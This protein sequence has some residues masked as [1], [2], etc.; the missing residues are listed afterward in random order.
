M[1]QPP[2]IL[3][4]ID[5]LDGYGLSRQ[6]ELLVAHQLA[7]GMTPTV[8]A[9]RGRRGLVRR[10]GQQGLAIR[11]LDRRWVRDP[12]VAV[13]LVSELRRHKYDLLHLWGHSAVSY[14]QAVDRFVPRGPRITSVP[15]EELLV[16]ID[17]PP[18]VSTS[19]AEFLAKEQLPA[20][21]KLIAVAGPLV[22]S[23]QVD[24]AIWHF[25]LVRTLDEEVCLLIFGDGPDNHRLERFTRLTSEPSAVRFLGYRRDFRELL[26]HVDVFWHT[27]K[28]ERALPQTVLEAMAA[29]IPVVVNETGNCRKLVDHGNTGYLVPENDRAIFA[30]YTRKL[31]QEPDHAREIG[32]SAVVDIAE[33]FA[34]ED[35]IDTYR[36]R[37]AAACAQLAPH[38]N[39]TV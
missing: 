28:A 38:G 4:L 17:A 2:R 1:S 15:D 18:T 34:V 11:T 39:L 22:R 6:L 16:G 36:E 3:H 35:V 19:R 30:R 13:R 7:Q 23:Q 24:E 14:V 26:T 27:A 37:Y 12:F 33:R 31:L 32:M 21:A 29:G 25:E 20:N 10:L 9:L 5:R 8:L